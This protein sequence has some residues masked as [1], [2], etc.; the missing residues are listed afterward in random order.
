MMPEQQRIQDLEAKIR[1]IEREKEILKK[2]TG[3][4]MSDW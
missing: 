4:L 1:K 2:A 3:L